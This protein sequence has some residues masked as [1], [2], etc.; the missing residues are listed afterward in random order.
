M[1]YT[2][3]PLAIATYNCHHFKREKVAYL[4]LVLEEA[5]V[6]FMQE[7]CLFQSQFAEFYQIGDIS[8][9]AV[10]AMDDTLPIVGR[11]F[12]GCCIIWKNS[13]KVKFAPISCTSNRICAGT[14]T[15]DS[16]LTILLVNTYLPCDDRYQSS[17]YHESVDVLNEIATL[18]FNQAVDLTIVAGD[19]NTDLSRSTPQ[20]NVLMNF[21]ES[22]QLF[23]C[24]DVPLAQVDYTFESKSHNVTSLIDHILLS[25]NFSPYIMDYKT[26]KSIDNLSDHDALTC[27]L[28]IDITVMAK[29]AR[30]FKCK[31]AWHK[32]SVDDIA[33]YKDHLDVLLNNIHISRE[34]LTCDNMSCDLHSEE[35]TL[36]LSS[37][38]DACL[39][40]ENNEIPTTG[41]S[42]KRI[43]GWN[44]VVRQ[45]RMES[46]HWHH[47]WDRL[48]RPRTGNIYEKM[49]ETRKDYH[50]SIRHCKQNKSL[51]KSQK[52]AEALAK[53]DNRNFWDEVQRLNKSS[54]TVPSFIDGEGDTV[55]IANIFHDK[56]SDVYKSV[57]YTDK[58]MSD[59]NHRIEKNLKQDFEVLKTHGFCIPDI[60][61]AIQRIKSGKADGNMGLNS[62]CIVNGT[63]KLFVLLTLFFRIIL[64]HGVV[65]DELLLGTMSPIPKSKSQQSSDNYRAITLISVIL[66][67]FDYNI[68]MKYDKELQTDELQMGFKEKCSTTLCSSMMVETARIFNSNS[69]KV[70]SVLLDA[71]KAFDRIEFSRLFNILLDRKLN[72]VYVRC[73][74]YMYTNQRLR[75]HWNGVYSNVFYVTNGV[76]QG[77][78]LSPILFGLYLDKLI[79]A[80]RKSGYG[81]YVG[82][83]FVGCLAYADD[84][85]LMSPTKTG[86]RQMLQVCSA[87]AMEYKLKFNGTKSQYIIFESKMSTNEDIMQVFDIDLKNQESVTHLGHTIYAST[88]RNDNDGI[89]ATF[90]RQFN[91]FRSK[92]GNVA[93]KVQAHLF[94]T[95][96]SSFYGVVLQPLNAL[97]KI[98]IAW[99]K[100]L[101]QVWKLP[102]RTHC[103]VLRCL[104]KGLCERHMFI[105][106]FV[107]FALNALNHGSS[108][109]S[110]VMNSSMKVGMSPFRQ[111]VLF[112]C[113]ELN[114]ADGLLRDY[115][116]T[117]LKRA[118]YIQCNEQC[119]S[120]E[121]RLIAM[122]VAELCDVN[123]GL[124]HCVLN[125]DERQYI[126]NELC[127]N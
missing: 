100:S 105:S 55:K 65:P 95:Y 127:V 81:C 49:K 112:S 89:I 98:H 24:L 109:V 42:S 28:E 70:Y 90:Y 116:S 72:S 18:I 27:K 73:L 104:S 123:D 10:S 61:K 43:P 44:D 56:F 114:I 85:V 35:I 113:R 68:L 57:P 67:L 59:L 66:K 99:R 46:L 78:V 107:I 19:F 37:I 53:S 111:N 108:V 76:K 30:I 16:G 97:Q 79:D 63:D 54:R 40:A 52:M 4:K 6:I 26:L 69:S 121:N 7:H 64:V 82:P 83:Y 117:A 119:K 20:V 22:T 48:S 102:Y 91:W 84:V 88:G 17:S 21:I 126:L 38:V 122:T 120:Y 93:S 125:Y 31:A 29:K 80:L 39:T 34:L 3:Q 74:L 77:G 8:Y 101:R 15:L 23:N 96:C 110:F 103:A 47:E 124:Q 51:I 36:F 94:E 13:L 33:N 71:T 86:L 12:G 92:F 14:M 106:R 1:D 5:G 32:A 87:F 2:N 9:H 25:Q 41:N 60:R 75:I 62:D 45:K 11:P 118:L 115:S 58:D 50:K